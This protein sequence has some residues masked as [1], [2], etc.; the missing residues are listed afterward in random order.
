MKRQ[1]K[2]R[3]AGKTSA[4]RKFAEPK[5]LEQYLAL[6]E[7]DQDLWTDTGQIVTKVKRGATFAG[8]CR[9]LD[10]DPR[11]VQRLAKRALRKLRNGRWAVKGTER[12][13][14]VLQ[15]LTPEG[16]Q[17]IGIRDSRQASMLGDY[18]HAIDLYRDTGDSSKV[19][20][21]RGK[22]VIDADGE[23]FPFLT[24]L[25]EIDRLGS[26]GVLSFESLY[27]RVA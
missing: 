3:K 18:W 6:N 20:T 10:R 5:N 24:D 2:K 19:L 21:F 27:E 16:R 4:R 13:L 14:R 22:Y 26:A 25:A 17:Q 23:R 15:K 11:T 1:G 7:R 9:E 8:A 12:L